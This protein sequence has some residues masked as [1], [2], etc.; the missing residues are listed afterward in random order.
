[1]LPGDT[2]E[3]Q[4]HAA[5]DGAE[6]GDAAPRG[7]DSGDAP[8]RGVGDGPVA[9]PDAAGCGAAQRGA[10]A[11]AGGAATG[12]AAHGE[13]PC[14]E[15]DDRAARSASTHPGA[16]PCGPSRGG[17]AAEAFGEVYTELRHCAHRLMR[18]RHGAATL[19]PT[20]LANEAWMRVAERRPELLARS[21][22]FLA[23]AATVMR[24]ILVDHAR[25]RQRRG[26]AAATSDGEAGSTLA[27]LLDGA[28]R[29]HVELLALDEALT[30]LAT[31]D[32]KM[33]QA[34]ELRFFAGLDF[35]VIASLLDT[36]K[37]TLERHWRATR[38]W[39]FR[40]LS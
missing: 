36:P 25:K 5:G 27:T 38:A 23:Y 18:R 10:A 30:E 9:R 24:T 3:S 34:V 17:A 37:R 22:E 20:A 15:A 21:A 16:A 31:F 39:L 12:A 29:R 28:E 7:T 32:A 2:A 14:R 6:G 19:E 13:G 35:N 40:R 1:V 26:G 33:A 8:L 4:V 11:A